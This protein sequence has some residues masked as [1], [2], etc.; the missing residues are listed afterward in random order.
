MDSHDD[1]C[2]KIIVNVGPGNIKSPCSCKERFQDAMIVDIRAQLA[3][4]SSVK[5]DLT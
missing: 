4:A 2:E 3:A 1:F 5:K